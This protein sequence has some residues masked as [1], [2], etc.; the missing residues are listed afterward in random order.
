MMLCKGV[1]AEEV[2]KNLDNYKDYYVEFKYDGIRAFI[3]V[4]NGNVKI[5]NRDKNNITKY[6]PEIVNEAK[7]LPDNIYDG[8]IV[9]IENENPANV[10]VRLT[11]NDLKIKLLSKMY[12]CRFYCFDIVGKDYCQMPLEYRKKVLDKI[13][14]D[15]Y[16][17]QEF[18]YIVKVPYYEIDMFSQLWYDVVKVLNKEGLILKH[19][20]S[21]YYFDKRTEYWIKVKNLKEEIVEIV[22]YEKHPAG[23]VFITKDGNRIN[24]NG[25]DMANKVINALSQGKK[26]LFEIEYLEKTKDNKFRFAKV[27]KVR[28]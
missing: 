26:I 19:K 15:H 10:L 9:S 28:I 23:A 2:I 25:I 21:K 13:W 12:P 8:E 3:V 4:E 6:F 5:I 17:E 18:K 20:Q 27:K 7:K 1:G 24:L 14:N 11:D 16:F 22:D